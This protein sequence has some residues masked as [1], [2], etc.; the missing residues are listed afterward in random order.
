LTTLDC[1]DRAASKGNFFS[2]S[3]LAKPITQRIIIEA[4]NRILFHNTLS[5]QSKCFSNGNMIR[6]LRIYV[7]QFYR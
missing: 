4:I 5:D 1:Y 6:T 3:Q 7:S 2:R